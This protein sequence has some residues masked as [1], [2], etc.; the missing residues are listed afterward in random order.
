M[1]AILLILKIIGI[2][3]LSIL[4]ILAL[5][6]VLVL[7]VSVHY[8][9]SGELTEQIC[10][11]GKVHWLLHILT[12]VFSYEGDN[13]DYYLKL[14]G[15]RRKFGQDTVTAE[16]L[17]E[18]IKEDTKEVVSAAVTTQ[19][20]SFGDVKQ[21][22]KLLE[23]K[24]PEKKNRNL[25]GRI[26]DV[27]QNFRNIICHI[28]EK[29]TDIKTV[30]TD[31]TNRKVVLLIWQELKKL[32]KHARFRKIQ[33]DLKFSLADPALTGQVLGI[34]CMLPVLYQYEFHI[35]PDFESEEMYVRGTF[36][37]K[38]HVRL[39]HL[40]MLAIRLLKEK[41]FRI[42]IKRLLKK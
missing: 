10:I 30:L 4:G 1:T 3:L 17:Q 15:I 38:G 11:H 26:K 20:D 27:I 34:L 36:S 42:F 24:R 35:Y 18:N 39:N 23:P 25:F 28:P 6:V 5:L 41:E 21:E 12:F 37:I 33:T 14:F 31:E 16:N 32:L 13:F 19:E 40:L 8:C 29:I 7:F 9:I 2:I 22:T